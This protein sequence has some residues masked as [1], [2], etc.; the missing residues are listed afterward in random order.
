MAV[1]PQC[2]QL[3][4]R[5]Q[6]MKDHEYIRDGIKYYKKLIDDNRGEESISVRRST[7]NAFLKRVHDRMQQDLADLR[8]YEDL[9]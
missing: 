2:L 9:N 1:G 3:Q 8:V 4:L 5:S 6:R 7:L